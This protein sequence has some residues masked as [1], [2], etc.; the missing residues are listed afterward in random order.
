M[1]CVFVFA[2]ISLMADGPQRARLPIPPTA[3]LPSCLW[4]RRIFPSLPGCRLKDFC[5]DASSALF[6]NPSSNND[7]W[8][9]ITRFLTL[10]ATE[11]KSYFEQESNSRLLHDEC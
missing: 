8:I 4:S 9:L 11:E 2:R 5:R 7:G 3:T 1:Y 6:F 10:S